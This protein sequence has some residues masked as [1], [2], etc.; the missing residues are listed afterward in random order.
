MIARTL[1]RRIVLRTGDADVY[2]ALRYLECEPEVEGDAPRDLEI[3]IEPEGG[4]FRVAEEEGPVTEHMTADA[5]VGYLHLRLFRLAVDERPESPL[6]H[7]ACLRKEGRRLLLVGTEGAGKTTLTL[8]LRLAG[9]DI[10]GDENVFINA[11]SVIARPRGL[12]VKEGTLLQLP[13]IADRITQAPHLRDLNDRK[14]YNLDPRVL[15]GSW[16]IRSGPVHR[17]VLLRANHGGGSSI[18]PLAPLAAARE[19]MAEIGF[20][21]TGRGRA[22]AAL[23]NLTAGAK[24]FDLSLGEPVHAVALIDHLMAGDADHL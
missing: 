7:A 6:L 21:E 23:A 12:R 15:G 2:A 13:Q 17:I 10:E 24:A 9:Y 19:I 18:R 22:V 11:G 14:I 4:H 1:Q 16:E 20:P 5:V 3:R 8:R